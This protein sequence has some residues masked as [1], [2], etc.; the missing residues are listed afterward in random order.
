MQLF[1]TRK[2]DP[3]RSQAIKAEVTRRLGLADNAVVMVSELACGDADCP[4][5]ETVIALLDEQRRYRVTFQRS[6]EELSSENVTEAWDEL[7]RQRA[8]DA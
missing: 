2:L 1:N 6:L 4:E 3:L 7:A 5:V 8:A